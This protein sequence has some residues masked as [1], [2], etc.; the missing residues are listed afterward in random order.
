MIR[1]FES[2]FQLV[3]F[4]YQNDIPTLNIVV[5][6]DD[7]ELVDM[8]DGT[9]RFI[10][11]PS[12]PYLY[13]GQVK[14]WPTCRPSLFRCNVM[15]PI[16]LF[17]EYIRV[18]EFE[19][20]L[21]QH[22]AVKAMQGERISV[23]FIA[24]AQ[25]YGL[26]TNCLDLTSSADIAAFFATCSFADGRYVPY[27]DS[28]KGV[29]FRAPWVLLDP[30]L[31]GK[32][33]IVGF[34]PLKRP[35]EQKAWG[36]VLDKHEDFAQQSEVFHFS[37]SKKGSEYF[38]KMF[39]A[40][41]KLFPSDPICSYVDRIRQSKQYSLEAFHRAFRQALDRNILGNISEKEIQDEL[42]KQK[43][44]LIDHAPIFCLDDEALTTFNQQWLQYYRSM[45][46]KLGFRRACYPKSK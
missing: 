26:S 18:A 5:D 41:S 12:S 11:G 32:I 27:A 16:D 4:L 1:H 25:H 21:Q 6:K 40:G 30:E 39:E 13:R 9:F 3:E 42:L 29:I 38:Y 24:L 28:D 19:L 37:Q 17:V 23:D 34:Q 20:L 31:V 44:L 43:K 10:P 2:I 35:A 8:R 7:F 22:P 33:K 46:S 15:N 36:Y 45:E 14:N